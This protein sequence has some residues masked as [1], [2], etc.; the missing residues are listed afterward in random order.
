M[1]KYLY[2]IFMTEVPSTAIST[3]QTSL[4]S[5]KPDVTTSGELSTT[6]MTTPDE[7]TMTGTY[8][9]TLQ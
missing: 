1:A 8:A 6:P 5:T 4:S 9:P 7:T 3:E 2:L